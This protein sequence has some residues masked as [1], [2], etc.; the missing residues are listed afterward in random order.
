MTW[1]SAEIEV[2]VALVTRLVQSQHPDLISASI[3]EVPSGFDNTIW[4]LGDD[5]VVRLP[6]RQIAVSLIENE[7]RWLPLL[8][9]RLPLLVPL[10]VRVGTPSDLFPWP[11]TIAPWI[12]GIPGNEVNPDAL[13]AAAAP[14]GAFLRALHHDAPMDAPTNK[15]RSVALRNHE[16]SF[17]NRLDQVGDAVNQDDVQSIWETSLEADGWNDVPQW[18]HGDPHP[19]NLIFDDTALVGII[20]FG[21]LCAG[22]PAT[23]LAGGFLALPFESLATFLDAYGDIH[24]ST[25]QRTLGWTVHFGVMFIL[26]GMAEEPTYG[27]IG[28]RAIRNA[29]NFARSREGK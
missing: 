13:N 5:L 16:E 10:P 19:A 8:A 7:Q 28:H 25:V 21:D 20:D 9:P 23:D 3:R 29:I 24:D 26:L 22:D 1:P 27:L 14:L 15:F 12:K 2:D 6:R 4:R 17:R 11:W 18:I